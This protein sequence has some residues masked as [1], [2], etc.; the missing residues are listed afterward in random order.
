MRKLLAALATVAAISFI[1]GPANAITVGT[2]P[3]IQQGLAKTDLSSKRAGFVVATSGPEGESAGPTAA[4]RRRCATASA[5][6]T[7]WTATSRCEAWGLGFWW[8]TQS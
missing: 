6:Q 2:A 4:S 8:R 3:G 5:A 7:G 1:P